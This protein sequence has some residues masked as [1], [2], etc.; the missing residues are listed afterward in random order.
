[1]ILPV[2]DEPDEDALAAPSNSMADLLF[3][4]VAILLLAFM[5]ILPGL[6]LGAWTHQ[7]NRRQTTSTP[8]SQISFKSAGEQATVFLARRDSLV[9]PLAGSTP[10]GRDAILD[11][12]QLTAML[13]S[14]IRQQG[15]A[16]L[17]VTQ[18][19]LETAFEFEALA[20]SRGMR[21]IRQI[22]FDGPCQLSGQVLI[23]ECENREPAR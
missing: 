10:I 5:S 22:R 12:A 7:Q 2:F 20:A 13:D 19:G 9:L 23:A 3:T 17:F 4:M 8:L 16:T 6:A 18:D 14:Q 21:R 1:M 11:N 15:V